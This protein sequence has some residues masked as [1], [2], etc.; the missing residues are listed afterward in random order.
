MAATLIDAIC[1]SLEMNTLGLIN[2][3]LSQTMLKIFLNG[4][5]IE[6][7]ELVRL[8]EDDDTNFIFIPPICLP[9]LELEGSDINWLH[10]RE[11]ELN[12]IKES[13]R[14]IIE[15]DKNLLANGIGTLNS[16]I[17]I[18]KRTPKTTIIN[19]GKDF[20]LFT[21]NYKFGSLI[22]LDNYGN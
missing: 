10:Y 8:Y 9:N 20:H 1:F 3:K 2:T 5:A 18:Q 12:S 15:L 19:L 14:G 11:V 4:K 17:S 21:D 22:L 13:I 7:T 16:W 6:I